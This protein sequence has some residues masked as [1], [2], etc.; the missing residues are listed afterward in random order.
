M[1]RP[2][3]ESLGPAPSCSASST[4]TSSPWARRTRPASTARSSIPGG[5]A[6]ERRTRAR[7]LVGRLGRGGRSEALRRCDRDR[8]RRLDPPAGGVHRHR[9]AQ[10]D[11]RPLLALGHRAL[12]RRSTR[13]GRSPARCATPRSFEAMASVDPKDTTSADIGCRTT[14]RRSAGAQGHEDRRAERIPHGRHARRD[15]GALAQGIE[16][17]RA[18]GAEIVDI[19]LPHTKYALPAYYIVRLPKRRRISRATTACVTG[20]ASMATTSLTCTKTRARGFGQEVKRRVLIGTYV[21]SAGI[22]TRTTPRPEGP[23]ADQARFRGRRSTRESTRSSARY[24][25]IGVRHRD[26]VDGYPVEMYFN[27]ISA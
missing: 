8:H 24:A 4:W 18:A 20:F 13:R 19:S 11:L 10:A 2:S 21:L 5:S 27:D 16:W 15:R 7:R 14:R 1:N 22:T 9:R 25:L 3:R 17:Y 6:A 26:K 23:Y 12:P